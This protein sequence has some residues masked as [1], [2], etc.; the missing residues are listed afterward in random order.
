M[1]DEKK[2]SP[3]DSNICT[4]CGLCSDV[5]PVQAIKFQPDNI[6][7]HLRPQIDKEKCIDCGLCERKCPS[8]N[9]VDKYEIIETYAAWAKDDV[10][11]YSSSSGGIASS[12][13][14]YITSNNGLIVGVQMDGVLS[15]RFEC[16]GSTEKIEEFKKSKY[17]Q[18]D[19]SEIY[20]TVLE[21]LKTGKT[22]AF[23]GLPCH[24][25]A[26]KRMAEGHDEKLFLVDLICHGIP[27][28]EVFSDYL[29]KRFPGKN[30][31]DIK[32]RDPKR[33][34]VL[35]VYE[36]EK[37]CYERGYKEDPF[38]YAFMYGDL[39]ADACYNC[40]YAG[41]Q[42]VSDLTIGD[43]WGLGKK[44]PFEKKISKVSCVLINTEKGKELFES[45]APLLEY[46]KR[47]T[48]EAVEGNS[49]L[50]HASL[51]GK[52]RENIISF[53]KQENVGMRLI[54]LYGAST[55]KTYKKRV[56]TE[57]VKSIGIALGLKKLKNAIKNKM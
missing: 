8:N 42:R 25:A 53:Y 22:V 26:M 45:V 24:C 27:S 37:K 15:P 34:E 2:K 29:R 49:Q 51:V 5:C 1:N 19:H 35:A 30:I 20:K 23:V 57:A 9:T 18:V 3:V 11:H 16:T 14:E 12:I 7:G 36:N 38:L 44:I 4:G 6:L 32:F 48:E 43:F 47:S 17:L 21:K 13:Y 33:G 56:R 39:F 54:Q 41:A 28:Y 10:K 52:H 50:Q 31:S 46:E 40:M 55:E